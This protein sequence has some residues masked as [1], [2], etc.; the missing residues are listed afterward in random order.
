MKASLYYKKI[1]VYENGLHLNTNRYL[2]RFHNQRIPEDGTGEG[3][4]G[5]EKEGHPW[6]AKRLRD[7]HDHLARAAIP[8]IYI[9]KE[10][11]EEYGKLIS[12]AWG[13]P[14]KSY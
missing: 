6:D 11:G 7:I 5:G 4:R 14:F 13:V 1:E 12:K 3:D 8:M 2:R 9:T 10:K